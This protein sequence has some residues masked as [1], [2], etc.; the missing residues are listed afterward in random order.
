MQAQECA[1]L[2]YGAVAVNAADPPDADVFSL[3]ATGDPVPAIAQATKSRGGCSP[4]FQWHPSHL[5]YDFPH[6]VRR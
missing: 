6:A 5:R 3:T 4:S 1:E 2:G